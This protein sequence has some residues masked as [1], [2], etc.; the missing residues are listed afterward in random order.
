[1]PEPE[2]GLAK[3]NGLSLRLKMMAPLS[4]IEVAAVLPLVPPLPKTS[5]PPLLVVIGA[6]ELRFARAS[7]VPP[8]MTIVPV[9]V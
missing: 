8:L 3:V 5:V 4:T 1:M 7:S 6:V 2:I 9:V